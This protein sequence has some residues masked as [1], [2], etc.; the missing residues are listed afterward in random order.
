[1]FFSRWY[2]YGFSSLYLA[3]FFQI[4]NQVYDTFMELKKYIYHE[5]TPGSPLLSTWHTIVLPTTCWNGITG[6]ASQLTS[7]WFTSTAAESCLPAH[8]L[9]VGFLRA[10]PHPYPFPLLSADSFPVPSNWNNFT[11][12]TSPVA[13]LPCTE[14]TSL[15]N[16]GWLNLI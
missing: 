11:L 15:I 8:R 5:K 9:H 2:N 10:V 14:V 7:N 3:L 4:E 1:M 13:T 16:A 6:F 12:V